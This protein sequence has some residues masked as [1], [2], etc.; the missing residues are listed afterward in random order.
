MSYSLLIYFEK[1]FDIRSLIVIKLEK[2]V[3]I[4]L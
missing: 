4:S 3:P 1:W 2:K